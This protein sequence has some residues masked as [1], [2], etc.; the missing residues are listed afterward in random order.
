MY[1]RTFIKKMDRSMRPNGNGDGLA[2]S[3]DSD[4]VREFGMSSED[5][6][7]MRVYIEDGSPVVELSD[8]GSGFSLDELKDFAAERNWEVLDSYETTDEWSQTY[9]EQECE[10]RIEVDSKTHLKDKPVNNII[11]EGPPIE[12]N[13]DLK[14]FERMKDSAAAADY[15]MTIQIRDSDGLWERLKQRSDD[16]EPEGIPDEDPLR[17]LVRKVDS[18]TARLKIRESSL[19]MSLGD[20]AG[21]V[22]DIGE[23]SDDCSKILMRP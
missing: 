23:V 20:L 9:E 8:F 21:A 15:E 3:F 16:L 6:L 4:T 2:I 10:V 13:E 18:V 5:E 1:G 7:E 11:I 12:L 17:Q 19:Q 14:Q 22:G